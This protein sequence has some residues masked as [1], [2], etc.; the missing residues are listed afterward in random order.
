M[1]QTYEGIV[2]QGSVKLPPGADF[3]DGARV[4]VTIIPTLDV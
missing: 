1:L 2:W 4:Y 3:P